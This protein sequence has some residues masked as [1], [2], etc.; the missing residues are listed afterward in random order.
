MKVKHVLIEIFPR[1]LWVVEFITLVAIE[2]I[3]FGGPVTTS[4]NWFL[5]I[6]IFLTIWGIY[7]LVTTFYKLAKP[8][9]TKELVTDGPYKYVRHPMYVSIH[10]LLFGLGFIFFS[11]LWFVIMI[12]FFPIWYIDC[13]LEEIQM[14]DLWGQ[15]YIDYKRRTGMFFPKF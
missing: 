12:I 6:G 7:Y 11:G 1:L 13:M 9:F 4:N 10:I 8:M 14:T 2:S 5:F 15:N 3:F